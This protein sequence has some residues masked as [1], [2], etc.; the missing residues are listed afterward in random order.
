MIN[1]IDNENELNLY[2]TVLGEFR[3]EGGSYIQFE[4]LFITLY[5]RLPFKWIFNLLIERQ[6]IFEKSNEYDIFYTNPTHWTG[7]MLGYE[8][9]STDTT[10]EGTDIDSDDL[11]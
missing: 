10:V 8:G 4:E 7:E 9:Y 6:I 11:A 5:F 1:R 2:T 3:G